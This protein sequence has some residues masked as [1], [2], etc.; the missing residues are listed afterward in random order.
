MND[1]PLTRVYTL[2]ETAELL[3]VKEGMLRRYLIAYETQVEALPRVEGRVNA[4]R[5]VSESVLTVLKSARAL[6]LEQPGKISAEEA[7]KRTVGSN[8]EVEKVGE[9][10]PLPLERMNKE[11]FKALLEETV[12]QAQAPLMALVQ[13]QGRALEAQRAEIAALREQLT[14]AL[15]APQSEAVQPRSWWSRLFK[16]KP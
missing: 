9:V 10:S 3:G 15:P 14:R 7:V 1:E 5:L 16:Q 8:V 12:Q 11:T 2:T 6:V 4:P 13:E